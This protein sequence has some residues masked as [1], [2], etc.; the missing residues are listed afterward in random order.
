MKEKLL[1]LLENSYAEYSKFKVSCVLVC[2]DKKEF[3]GVN[4]ENSSFGAT[5]CAERN[6]IFSAITCGYKASD[7]DKIY[8]MNNGGKICTPCMLC[9]QVFVEFFSSDVEVYCYDINGNYKKYTVGI[10][11]PDSFSME[12]LK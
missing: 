4:V 5:I 12:D 6:A 10:L 2:K 7:F 11:C 1:T 3:Y 9:R 8:I